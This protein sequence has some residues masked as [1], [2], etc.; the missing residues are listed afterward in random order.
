MLIDNITTCS[1]GPCPNQISLDD[2]NGIVCQDCGPLSTIRYCSNSHRLADAKLHY[3]FCGLQHLTPASAYPSICQKLTWGA[4]IKIK[5]TNGHNNSYRERQLVHFMYAGSG[6][7][8]TIFMSDKGSQDFS[9]AFLEKDRP[10]G[11]V[12]LHIM[13]KGQQT[14]STKLSTWRVF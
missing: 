1:N 13:F 14:P 8:Y 12:L 4:P 5:D 9:F 11:R 3:F 10:L 6:A 2:L 7:D